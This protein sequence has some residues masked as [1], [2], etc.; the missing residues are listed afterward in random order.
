MVIDINAIVTAR[1][2]TRCRDAQCAGASVISINAIS[3]TRRGCRINREVAAIAIID[4]RINAI[5]RSA[6]RSTRCCDAKCA[7]A[8]VF[9]INEIVTDR[10]GGRVN[11][12]IDGAVYIIDF[13]IN[14]IKPGNTTRSST[15]CCDT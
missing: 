2:C 6:R 1:C 10:R 12:E 11:R 3:A 7:G 8:E 14:A 4:F 5:A 13:R 9:R 15:R